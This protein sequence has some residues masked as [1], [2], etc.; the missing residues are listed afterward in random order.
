MGEE[1]VGARQSPSLGRCTCHDSLEGSEEGRFFY[2]LP[3]IRIWSRSCIRWSRRVGLCTRSRQSPRPPSACAGTSIHGVLVNPTLFWSTSMPE[4]EKQ[5]R[6]VH[7]HGKL[8]AV[9]MDGEIGVPRISSG[10]PHR[11][12]RGRGTR[13]R[14]ATLHRGGRS[15]PGRTRPSSL[16]FLARSTSRGPRR[17][18]DP[19]GSLAGGRSR[20]TGCDCHV[21]E[22][23]V[24][25]ANLCALT[26]VLETPNY[27]SRHRSW[28][29][30]RRFAPLTGRPAV[31]KRRTDRSA[32]SAAGALVSRPRDSTT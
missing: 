9:H 18:R 17:R 3:T 14:W 5:G 31:S 24:A 32:H 26:A 15:R 25:N 1:G 21:H 7:Q 10:R 23:Q 29:S 20:P 12:C 11:H 6:V 30:D 4:Y 22:N 28:T 19:P 8:M 16:A 13:F 27:R 2:H